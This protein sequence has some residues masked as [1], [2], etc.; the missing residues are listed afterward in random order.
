M[1]IKD[2]SYPQ[3][4]FLIPARSGS[5]RIKDK[6]IRL[7]GGWPL[8]RWSV[9][10]AINCQPSAKN[11]LTIVSSDSP[12]YL[13]MARGWGADTIRR[14]VKLAQSYSTDLDVVKH[15]IAHVNIASRLRDHAGLIVYLRPTTPFRD[16][17]IVKQAI[18]LMV[19]H[20]EYTGLRSIEEMGESAFKS[21][22]LER[23][24]LIKSLIASLDSQGFAGRRWRGKEFTLN[25]G[26]NSLIS[27]GESKSDKMSKVNIYNVIRRCKNITDL[28]NQLLPPTYRGNGYVDIIRVEQV[29]R[30]DLWG[31]NCYG[32]ITSPTIEIDTP[33]DWEQAEW[34]CEQIHRTPGVPT[35]RLAPSAI[36]SPTSYFY[37]EK[38]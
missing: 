14:P 23:G 4:I 24:N 27:Q 37:E 22:V 7:L 11:R 21:F 3:L 29:L 35:H 17:K 6:N 5:K 9:E 30:D 2:I 13:I 15:A 10:C 28:P 26:A 36:A 8:M 25:I 1:G 38:I 31:C 19:C 16:P 18:D 34:K 12:K 32:F 20:P 33:E